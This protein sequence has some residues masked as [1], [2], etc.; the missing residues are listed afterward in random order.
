MTAVIRT[1]VITRED[2]YETLPDGELAILRLPNEDDCDSSETEPDELIPSGAVVID[3]FHVRIHVAA[4]G[5]AARLEDIVVWLDGL[6]GWLSDGT[7]TITRMTAWDAELS[8]K[9]E[10][11]ASFQRLD[12]EK[13]KKFLESR[14]K[15]LDGMKTLSVEA[16]WKFCEL[17]VNRRY[18]VPQQSGVDARIATDMFRAA[19]DGHRRIFLVSRDGDFADAAKLVKE[20][21]PQVEIDVIALGGP[22]AEVYAELKIGLRLWKA[23]WSDKKFAVERVLGE[24]LPVPG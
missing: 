11:A 6:N 4:K 9:G 18:W 23:T 24:E 17:K 21:F 7:V 5:K 13:K 12:P 16:E 3:G 2:F 10:H 20:H 8:K 1:I 15:K 19:L 22:P 14:S